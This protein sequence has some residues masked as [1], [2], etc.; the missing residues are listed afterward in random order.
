MPNGYFDPANNQYNEFNYVLRHVP[1]PQPHQHHD[2]NGCGSERQLRGS[3]RFINDREDNIR[4][5]VVRPGYRL[6]EQRR[7]RLDLSSGSATTGAAADAW[8]TRPRSDS[9]TTATAGFRPR[10]NTTRIPSVLPVGQ[11]VDPPR[12]EPFGDYRDPQGLGYNQ[13]DEYP[14]LPRW[15]TAVGNR[16]IWPTS[17]PAQRDRILP[18]ANH[19]KR[20]T[21]QDDL[22]WT[23]GRHNFK[24]GFSAEWASKTEPLSPN[25][26]GNYKF[27]H[28][29][30]NPSAPATVTRTRSSACSPPTPR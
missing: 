13:S 6:G 16:A 4:N 24:F 30:E 25:Y 22:S 8:S 17:T 26:G 27:G 5:N 2:P 23:R 12:L 18:T 9:A 3:F 21:F 11:G 19:N 14:Y 10:V 1:D 29:A 15:P 20:W 7:A 28:N